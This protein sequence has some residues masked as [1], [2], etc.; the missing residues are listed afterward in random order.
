MK[1][2]VAHD[3]PLFIL[4]LT[5]SKSDSIIYSKCC[6]LFDVGL[7]FVPVFIVEEHAEFQ[8]WPVSWGGGRSCK[9]EGSSGC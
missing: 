9:L 7:V 1:K 2:L 3:C 6:F 8:D 5:I 4:D